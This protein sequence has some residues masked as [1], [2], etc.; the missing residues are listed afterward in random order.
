MSHRSGRIYAG[1]L[2]A[3]LVA[4]AALYQ[5]IDLPEDKGATSDIAHRPTWP[6][7]WAYS[8]LKSLERGDRT[9]RFDRTV[10]TAVALG[11]GEREMRETLA[12]AALRN[13]DALSD[14]GRA[15]GADNL[16]FTLRLT[17]RRVLQESF[18]LRRE[19]VPCSL[20]RDGGE[21]ATVC[22]S[23]AGLRRLCDHPASDPTLRQWCLDRGATPVP[24]AGR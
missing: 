2:I 12:L 13:W 16:L 14:A 1:L 9:A 6:H 18:Q 5:H 21:I 8:A 4:S 22:E 20:W 15:Q 17:P 23:Y 10:A 19:A 11:P 24:R 7:A 3:G